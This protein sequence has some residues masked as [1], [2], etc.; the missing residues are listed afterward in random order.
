M[1]KKLQDGYVVETLQLYQE[2]E[3]IT[4]PVIDEF[5]LDDNFRAINARSGADINLRIISVRCEENH[6]MLLINPLG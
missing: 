2:I 3:L 4:S 6:G 1:C 5:V